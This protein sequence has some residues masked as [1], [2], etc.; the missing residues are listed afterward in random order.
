VCIAS[1]A[2]FGVKALAFPLLAAP[3]WWIVRDLSGA[4]VNHSGNG[5]NF[6]AEAMLV[7][8]SAF[9]FGVV[10]VMIGVGLRRLVRRARVLRR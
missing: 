8:M 10:G 2:I 3:G 5:D 4:F 7:S 9:T 6:G 1:G